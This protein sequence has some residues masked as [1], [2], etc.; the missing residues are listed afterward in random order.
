MATPTSNTTLG[1]YK[2]GAF[3]G[4][5]GAAVLATH[6]GYPSQPTM[7]RQFE[8]IQ[9]GDTLQIE[10]KNGTVASFEVYER[11]IYTPDNA[12]RQRIFGQTAVARL[13]VITCTGTWLPNQKTYSHRLIIYAAKSSS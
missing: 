4:N 8:T 13:A 1:W 3:P 2:Y 12:P 7:F 5:P 10:D 6:T 9:K 11:A